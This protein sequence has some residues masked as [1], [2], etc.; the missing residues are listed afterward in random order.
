MIALYRRQRQLLHV[1]PSHY[2]GTRRDGERVRIAGLVVCRQAPQ[3][4][5]GVLFLSLEDE[6]GLVNV[7]VMPA[8]KERYRTQVRQAPMLLIDG[9]LQ[10]EGSV[11]SVLADEVWRFAPSVIEAP[12]AASDRA[13]AELQHLVH[14]FR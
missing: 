5:N 6:W 7:I 14:N 2:L 10:R 1:T 4:A 12:A 8:V 9:R 11:V 3:T 13:G